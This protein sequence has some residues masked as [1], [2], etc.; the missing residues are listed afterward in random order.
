MDKKDVINK[1]KPLL[2]NMNISNDKKDWLS[3]YTE[4]QNNF[5]GTIPEQS[6]T[7]SSTEWS[8]MIL[9]ISMKVAARTI[10]GDYYIESDERIKQRARIK[11][12]ERILDSEQFKEVISKE[13]YDEIM[14]EKKDI[15][16]EGLVPVQPL[17]SLPT[18]KIFYMDYESESESERKRKERKKK[19]ERL[20]R[21]E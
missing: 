7:T 20:F 8:S 5:C 17:S 6:A 21:D 14:I 19:I 13:E 11:K 12:L 2:D 18:G 10:C 4:K 9:P 16:V 1:W 15:K 3:E